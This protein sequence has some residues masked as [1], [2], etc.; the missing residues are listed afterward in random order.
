MQVAKMH[1][2]VTGGSLGIGVSIAHELRRRGARVT[3]LGRD[4][5]RLR[6]VAAD[7][8]GG[9]VKL[10]LA[11]HEKVPKAIPEIEAEHG[12]I[13]ILVNNAAVAMVQAVVRSAPGDAGWQLAINTISPIEL[14]RQ[15]LPGMIERGRGHVVN[16]SS[17]AGC[18]A[19]PDLAVY[20]ASKAALHHFTATLQRE[21]RLRRAPVRA[22]VI[23]L[24][25]VAGTGMM[26]QARQSPLIATVSKRLERTKALPSL[27]ELQ[28]AT[29]VVT[30]IEKDQ[31][32][33]TVPKR[34]GSMVGIRNIPSRMQDLLLLGVRDD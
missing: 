18:S 31:D 15:V 10:D 4:E 33:A 29:G 26:E 23:T 30:A 19:V 1:A 7:I 20:S 27:T 16:V 6:Q 2:L 17:L 22:T 5:E 25:E 12:P 28:V 32:Y 14:T 34:I 9:W 3:V 24:G 11:D 21:L 13:D 8:D